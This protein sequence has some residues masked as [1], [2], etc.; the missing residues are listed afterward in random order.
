MITPPHPAPP[1]PLLFPHP[2]VK[3]ELINAALS[4]SI[5]EVQ[6]ALAE[7]DTHDL[8]DT[9]EAIDAQAWLVALVRALILSPSKA[10]KMLALPQAEAERPPRAQD[11]KVSRLQ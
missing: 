9:D 4:P 7:A 8:I 10:K 1:R 11:A 2:E 3:T 6:E 5:A